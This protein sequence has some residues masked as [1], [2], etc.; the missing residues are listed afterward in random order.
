MGRDISRMKCS[1]Y[2]DISVEIVPGIEVRLYI[3]DRSPA[4]RAAQRSAQ[5]RGDQGGSAA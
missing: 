1:G 3:R 4:G 5:C 2:R